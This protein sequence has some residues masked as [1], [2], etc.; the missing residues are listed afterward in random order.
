MYSVLLRPSPKIKQ[1]GK[2][3]FFPS[4]VITWFNEKN[5]EEKKRPQGGGSEK[6][7]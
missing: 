4:R 3:P 1:V 7:Y 5:N 6:V 2:D